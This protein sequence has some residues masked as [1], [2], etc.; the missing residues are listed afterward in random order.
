MEYIHLEKAEEMKKVI[1]FEAQ[2]YQILCETWDN[3][4]FI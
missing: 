4:E 1:F 3:I 2:T